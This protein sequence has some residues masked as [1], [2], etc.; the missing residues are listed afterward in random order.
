VAIKRSKSVLKRQR[1][2]EG[3][4]LRN[5]AVKTEIKTWVRKVNEALA[6]GDL[7]SAKKD[8]T[9]LF[10]RLDKAVKKGVIHR[11]KSANHKSAIMKKFGAA[12]KKKTS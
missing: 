6:K 10:S 9:V 8:M 2:V 12:S 11:N 5:H 4:T 7:E 3:R 1:Q